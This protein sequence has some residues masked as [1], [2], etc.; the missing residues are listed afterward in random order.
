MT[1]KR[2]FWANVQGRVVGTRLRGVTNDADC[3]INF[4]RE[5]VF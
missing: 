5:A 2:E 3:L 1:E 4:E